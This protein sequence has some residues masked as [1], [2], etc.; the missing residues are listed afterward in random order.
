MLPGFNNILSSLP[1]DAILPCIYLACHLRKRIIVLFRLAHRLAHWLLADFIE[2]CTLPELSLGDGSAKFEPNS[3]LDPWQL[4]LLT[5]FSV[6][7]KQ[8]PRPVQDLLAGKGALHEFSLSHK[9]TTLEPLEEPTSQRR[10]SSRTRSIA[11]FCLFH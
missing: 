8:A 5:L 6:G 7:Y 4:G 9:A 3:Y 2:D 10:G 1:I 11:I